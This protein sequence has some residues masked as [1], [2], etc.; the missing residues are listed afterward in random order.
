MATPVVL[1]SKSYELAGSNLG[2]TKEDLR[3]MIYALSPMDTYC[4]TNFGRGTAKS[5]THEWLTDALAAPGA[6]AFAEGEPFSAQANTNPTRL[7]N[8]CMITRR[9]FAV[10]GTA[11]KVANAGMSTLLAYQTA[12]K[13]KE[14]KRDIEYHILNN[15]PHSAGT[16]TSPRVAGAI[17]NWIYS[18]QHYK[19]SSQT[20][21]TTTA[22]VSGFATATNATIAASLTAYAETD[23]RD[24]LKLA[25][26]TGG[27]VD[28]V[29]GDSIAFN[30]ASTFTGVAQRF[31][32]V[33]SRQPAQMIG[34]SDVY[35][36][37]YGTVK[38]VLS[39]Y[40]VA[41]TWYA[42][43]TDMWEIA[44][45]RDFQILDS[46]R[47]GDQERRSLLAEWTLVCKNPLAN[48]KA[49]GVA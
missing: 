42:L 20:T 12:K 23:L 34:Y 21:M 15:N 22:P 19:A 17:P 41:N 5:V 33:A 46:G 29:I 35:V 30:R 25:W 38:L 31:R 9:D 1:A 24:M 45:L 8:T 3:D 36:S 44:Y 7:K 48:A 13:A 26:S 16:S 37:P 28:T 43:Q 47:D 4:F 40:C 39:R 10:T 6:N 32:D 2:P 18:G 14:N 49:H 11:Q 27:E